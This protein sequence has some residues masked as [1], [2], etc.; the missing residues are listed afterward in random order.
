MDG[1]F[2]SRTRPVNYMRREKRIKKVNFASIL[3]SRLLKDF[4]QPF[5]ERLFFDVRMYKKSPDTKC[6]VCWSV[7][8]LYTY[9]DMSHQVIQ[10]GVHT[11]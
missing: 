1:I 2:T 8:N 6:V 5:C 3:I 4:C 9:S 11:L 7:F 10:K